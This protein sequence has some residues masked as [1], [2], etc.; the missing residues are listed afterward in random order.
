M[1][2]APAHG[3]AS[4]DCP[5]RLSIRRARHLSRGHESIAPVIYRRKMYRDGSGGAGKWRGGDG[6]I[7]EIEHSEE[8]PSPFS[9]CS[10]VLN[11]RPAAV[12][13]AWQEL[14]GAPTF[15]TGA[16]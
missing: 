11:T 13:V 10:N 16:D 5:H 6:Q 14:A 8:P 2:A 1:P 4:R 15:Q 3:Q 9:P 12:M 7:I